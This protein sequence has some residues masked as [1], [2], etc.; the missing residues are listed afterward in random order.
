MMIPTMLLLLA[1]GIGLTQAVSDPRAVTLPWLR[2]GGIIAVTLLVVAVAAVVHSEGWDARAAITGIASPAVAFIV[3]LMAVQLGYRIRQRFAAAMGFLLAALSAT[4]FAG[5]I[6]AHQKSALADVPSL[7]PGDWAAL[8]ATVCLSAGLLGGFLM[9]MLLGHA[10]LTAGNEMTQ[11]PFRRVV[12]MLAALLIARALVSVALGL[13]PWLNAPPR[14]GSQLWL[15]MMM[16]ARYA[17]G[18]VVTGAF[19]YMTHDC[20]KRRANQSATGILYVAGVLIII[21]EW[22][23]LSLLD[24]TGFAF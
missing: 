4:V 20:V 14:A 23:A 8:L 18:I 22:S 12:L 16:V 2:L 3:Q 19:V 9:T 13:V 21:G 7:T 5:M 24:S 11:S 17:V 15:M 10:Y 6:L 1:A